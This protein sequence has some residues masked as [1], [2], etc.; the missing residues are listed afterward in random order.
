MPPETV[1]IPKGRVGRW[2]PFPML[3]IFT[4]DN[5]NWTHCGTYKRSDKRLVF[6]RP[7]GPAV[8]CERCVYGQ[9]NLRAELYSSG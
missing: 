6:G 5:Q 9:P 8:V 1:Y 2:A 7:A 3:H 4:S